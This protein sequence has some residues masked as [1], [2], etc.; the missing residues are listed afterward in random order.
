[1][2]KTVHVWCDPHGDVVHWM[3]RGNCPLTKYGT[4]CSWP[5][6]TPTHGYRTR[7]RADRV[8]FR[9]PRC[10]RLFAYQLT[11]PQEVQEVLRDGPHPLA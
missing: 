8:Y 10:Q 1:M 2:R 9:C 6:V 3:L 11:A 4:A 5:R 7:R